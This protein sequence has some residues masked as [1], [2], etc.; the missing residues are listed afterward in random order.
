MCNL[1]DRVFRRTG[2][3]LARGR[4]LSDAGDH[5]GAAAAFEA[6]LARTP[7]DAEAHFRLGIARRDLQQLDAAAAAYR[8]AIALRPAYIEAHNNLG[9]VLQMLGDATGAQ[10]AWRRAVELR[11]DFAQ[12]YLNLGRLLAAHGD[13][14]G[15]AQTF[16]AALAR[17]IETDSFGHLLSAL[18]G[19]TTA[20]AP[21]GYTRGLFDGFAAEFDHRLVD[22][23]DYRIPEILTDRVKALQPRRDLRVA[24]L[25]CGTGLCAVH[26]AGY[27]RS[28]AGID[29]S[30]AMLEKARARNLYDTLSDADIVD[31]LQRAPAAGCDLVLAADVFIYV[32]DLAAVFGGVARVLAPRGLFAFSVE[33]ADGADYTLLPSGRYAHA[34]D[35]L[36]RLAAQHG[37][38]AAESFDCR[39]RGDVR[40]RVVI[41]QKP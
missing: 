8:R 15:A 11:P 18:Q 2:A 34:S 23:L 35:Y 7:H 22:Q 1:F 33:S 3:A 10:A 4:R 13:A 12:P 14:A 41:L 25:G 6:V 20:R 17:G 26:L 24:D 39:I 37:L 32:G 40:G 31:W 5:A 21:A 38:T 28:L 27:C 36:Q 30:P 19:E 9:A 16:S 29:L